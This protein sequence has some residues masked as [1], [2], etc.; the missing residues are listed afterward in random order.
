MIPEK[1]LKTYHAQQIRLPKQATLWQEGD[2]ALYYYQIISGEVKVS[3]F[4]TEGKEFVQGMFQKGQSFG[5]PPLFGKFPYPATAIASTDSVLWRLPLSD[6][7]RLL[8]EHPQIHM[9]LTKMLSTRLQ[10]KAMMM[11]ELSIYEPEHR[12]LSII[13]YFGNKENKAEFEVPFTRQ[14]LANMTGLRVETVIRTVKALEQKGALSI[15]NRKVFR[16]YHT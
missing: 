6:V 15:I 1:V 7:K 4:S 14:E 8:L 2:R 9:L 10:Y 16:Y 11:K 3:N 5:E 13:D 12:V